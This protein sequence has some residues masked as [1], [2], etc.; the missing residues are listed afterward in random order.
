[1][2]PSS[3]HLC[4]STLHL[5]T[6]DGRVDL[7]IA[8]AEDA[9]MG[10]DA[11]SS[12]PSGSDDSSDEDRAIEAALLSGAKI[13]ISSIGTAVP[14]GGGGRRG[15]EAKKRLRKGK[16]RAP[17]SSEESSEESDD[18]DDDMFEG[19]DTTWAD[20]DERYIRGLQVSTFPSTFAG[21]VFCG[22]REL[23]K[24]RRKLWTRTQTS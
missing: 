1:M 3:L 7:A 11:P 17:S 13:R 24:S 22:S 2:C 16:A 5:Q 23:T 20:D 8:A 12:E 18:E 19:G 4:T 15:K 10:S 14:G 6:F 21:D 9:L